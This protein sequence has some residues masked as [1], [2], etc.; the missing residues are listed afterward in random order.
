MRALPPQVSHQLLVK[1]ALSEADTTP[2]R[3]WEAHR[4]GTRCRRHSLAVGGSGK[5]CSFSR[6]DL[7]PV[8]RPRQTSAVVRAQRESKRPTITR[9]DDAD[10]QLSVRPDVNRNGFEQYCSQVTGVLIGRQQKGDRLKQAII[11]VSELRQILL[12]SRASI[13]DYAHKLLI[14]ALMDSRRLSPALKIHFH[15][16]RTR[17]QHVN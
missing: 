3:M 8:H 6:F 9:D 4:A 1:T 10:P 15:R 7:R 17:H 13:R 12:N 16:P 2:V 5:Y 11:L 14:E